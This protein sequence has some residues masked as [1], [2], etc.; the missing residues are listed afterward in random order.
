M[1]ANLLITLQNY[2]LSEKAARVYLTVLE[3]WTSIASTIAR[4]AELNRVTTYTILKDMIKRGYIHEIK[5][6][7]ISYFSWV[8]PEI[9]LK[10]IENKYIKFKELLPDFLAVTEKFGNTTKVQF[11]EG[12]EG[13]NNLFMEF[14]AT[15][16]NMKVILW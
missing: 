10:D 11:L 7:D 14:A 8:S 3:L 12:N 6:N 2:G 16:T 9:F 4:R 15:K 13:L 1:D 5:K